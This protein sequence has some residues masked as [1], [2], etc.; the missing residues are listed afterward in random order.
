MKDADHQV[1]QVECHVQL[2]DTPRVICLMNG[3]QWREEQGVVQGQATSHL[4]LRIVVQQEQAH[5]F[6]PAPTTVL[7][8][9]R[10]KMKHGRAF[11]R[12]QV[13]HSADGATRPLLIFPSLYPFVVR[14]ERER[15]GP[16]L[17]KRADKVRG[18]IE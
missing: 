5:F 18:T 11:K 17:G 16:T 9:K 10:E 13:L 14:A 2:V 12:T 3:A 7:Y 1:V 6:Q 4:S 8:L 15:G